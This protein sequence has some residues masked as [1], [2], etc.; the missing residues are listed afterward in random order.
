MKDFV[1]CVSARGISKT[2]SALSI[3][4]D[5]VPYYFYCFMN[6]HKLDFLF[7]SLLKFFLLLGKHVCVY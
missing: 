5:F 2:A 6:V 3:S 1:F 4:F 7:R